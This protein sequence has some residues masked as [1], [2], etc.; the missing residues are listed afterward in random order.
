MN[1]QT[2]KNPNERKFEG[3]LHLDSGVAIE[4]RTTKRHYRD[5]TGDYE[6]TGKDT[7]TVAATAPVSAAEMR[8]AMSIVE[9]LEHARALSYRL[10]CPYT[11]AHFSVTGLDEAG[12]VTVQL[13][14]DGIPRGHGAAADFALLR[15][16]DYSEAGELAMQSVAFFRDVAKI[17]CGAGL[18]RKEMDDRLFALRPKR[19]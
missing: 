17:I 13:H 1:T 19:S 8:E 4:W 18:T 16:E 10:H 11:D 12:Q 3:A 9:T 15:P 14:R 7:I 2:K 5:E 6:I